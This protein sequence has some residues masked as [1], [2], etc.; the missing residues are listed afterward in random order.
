MPENTEDKTELVEA[1][2]VMAAPEATFSQFIT[3]AFEA[4]ERFAAD[5]EA[6]KRQNKEP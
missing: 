2:R 4:A 5:A 1:S 3:E 6:R